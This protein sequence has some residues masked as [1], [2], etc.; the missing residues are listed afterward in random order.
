MIIPNKILARDTFKRPIHLCSG[1]RVVLSYAVED[2]S[3]EVLTHTVTECHTFTE[4][5]IFE[6]EFEGRPAI[7]GL[8]VG[9]VK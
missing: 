7:G 4:G 9:P 8:F 1:D 3:T 5:V 6:D 2:V